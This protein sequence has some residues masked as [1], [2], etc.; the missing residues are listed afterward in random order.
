MK[1]TNT[2]K[3][4]GKDFVTIG[5]FSILLMAVFIVVSLPFMPFLSVAYPLIGVASAIFTAPVFMLMTYKVAKRGTVFLC[6]TIISLLYVIMG[7]VYLLPFGIAAG[8]L[9]EAIVWK[10]G[11]YRS[12]WY[13]SASFSVFC[14]WLYLGSSFLPI[15]IFGTEYYKKLLSGNEESAL[16]HIKFATSPLWAAG[17]VIITVIAAVIGCLIGR[18]LLKKHFIKAGVI[19]AE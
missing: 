9:C 18:R 13:N 12:F 3:L 6:S 4:M 2:Q 14:V 5:I 8:M 19:A 17:S 1:K 16:V 10:K 15:Y 11:A 7:Y